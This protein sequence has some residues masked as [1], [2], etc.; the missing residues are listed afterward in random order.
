MPSATVD[1]RLG[2]STKNI[3]QCNI[4]PI[5]PYWVACRLRSLVRDICLGSK[6]QTNLFI[7]ARVARIN[8]CAAVVRGVSAGPLRKHRD[9]GP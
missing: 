4:L 8:I 3:E 5:L 9:S 1:K 7:H 6:V 2:V